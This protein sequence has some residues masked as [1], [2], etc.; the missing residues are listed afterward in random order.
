M[1]GTSTMMVVLIAGLSAIIGLILGVFAT[2]LW[3]DYI[4]K[5]KPRE[6]GHS[7]PARQIEPKDEETVETRL[8]DEGSVARDTVFQEMVRFGYAEDGSRLAVRMDDQ[9]Y[10]DPHSMPGEQAVRLRF[11]AAGLNTWLGLP[12][13]PKKT[14]SEPSDVTVQLKHGK[15]GKKAS[16]EKEN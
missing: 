7:D 16:G 13:I 10:Q 14:E 1:I 12:D 11:Y 2:L 15:K 5:E 8:E 4:R 6:K 9:V 3:V